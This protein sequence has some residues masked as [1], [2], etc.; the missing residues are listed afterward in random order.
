MYQITPNI[1]IKTT[2]ITLLPF[3]YIGNSLADVKYVESSQCPSNYQHV[4]AAKVNQN[5]DT[6]CQMIPQWG[7]VRLADGYS[8]SGSGYKCTVLT[9]DT[10]PLNYSL[11]EPN[12]LKSKPLKSK[13]LITDIKVIRNNKNPP[14][15]SNGATW[16]PLEYNKITQGDK[17]ND[18][19][20]EDINKGIGGDDV[21]IWAKYETVDLTGDK[22]VITGIKVEHWPNWNRKCPTGYEALDK[23]TTKASNSCWRN[24]LCIQRKK[25]NEAFTS[26][27]GP[28]TNLYLNKTNNSS[29]SCPGSANREF[30]TFLRKDNGF[31][32]IHKSCGDGTQFFLC[33]YS[34]RYE[35]KFAVFGDMPYDAKAA[36]DSTISDKDVLEKDIIPRLKENA[37][38]KTLD[39]LVH[40]GDFGRPEAVY[41]HK[42]EFSSCSEQGRKRAF[43]QMERTDL[44]Y[45][46]TPGD[47]DWIDCMRAGFDFHDVK[48]IK[49]KLIKSYINNKS[50]NSA[51]SLNIEHTESEANVTWNL[52]GVRFATLHMI[53]SDNGY[54]G[55]TGSWDEVETRQKQNL[56]TLAKVFEDARNEN[57]SA[58]VIFFHVDAFVGGADESRTLEQICYDNQYYSE[59][60]KQ[61]KSKTI[62]F[63]KPV[64]IVH[65]DTNAY[66]YDK[67]FGDRVNLFRLNTT[68]DF[69]KIDANIV[70]I[71][72]NNDGAFFD[73]KGLLD[74]KKP[75]E[76]CDY[77][78]RN[79]TYNKGDTPDHDEL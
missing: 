6:Y 60:C 78:R 67:P 44:P 16:T 23:L 38:S 21:Y 27:L 69:A 8:I 39:F 47:N 25:V 9:N 13:R 43:D 37:K 48:A 53:G 15:S 42:P 11:C 22:S 76:K 79:F 26:G 4:S 45:I 12:N 30:Y 52:K 56:K 18:G 63:G 65:G 64:L 66:C 1:N 5:N 35:T 31:L 40:V 49:N 55:H 36:N 24:G 7:I 73:V 68:G 62:D 51:K 32:D 34:P 75:P 20:P 71:N 70:T 29:Q 57:S 74:G 17:N 58:V 41:L 61:L 33:S 19:S 3:L 59:F 77:T 50:I 2:I 72:T 10:R 28:I 14:S 46:Y 54:A